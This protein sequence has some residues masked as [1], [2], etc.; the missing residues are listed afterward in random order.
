M[1]GYVS[2][3]WK[4]CDIL[5]RSVKKLIYSGHLGYLQSSARN[6]GPIGE[7][8]ARGRS[9]SRRGSIVWFENAGTGSVR[10]ALEAIS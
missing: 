6:P 1:G 7:L 3:A 5:R 4:T 8:R 2:W 9:R 10:F